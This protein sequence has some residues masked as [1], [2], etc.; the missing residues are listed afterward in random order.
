MHIVWRGCLALGILVLVAPLAEACTRTT[1]ISVADMTAQAD[2]I[3]RAKAVAAE[4]A[5]PGPGANRAAAIRFDVLEVMKGDRHL[6]TLVL[7][8]QLVDRDDFNDQAPPRQVRPSGRSGSCYTDEYRGGAEYLLFLRR[9]PGTIPWTTRWY[10][11][12][13]VNDQLT[14]ADDPWA[15]WVRGHLE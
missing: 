13:P 14:G 4:G 7:T 1:P 3:V 9:T 5:E 11:L 10:P 8:G 2:A 6:T 15:R 12:G